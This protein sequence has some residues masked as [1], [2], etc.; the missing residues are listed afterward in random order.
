MRSSDMA[1]I[2]LKQ[3]DYQID[4]KKILDSIDLAVE[5]NDYLTI[6]G[7][8][9]SGKSTVL[10][11]MA[12]MATATAGNL[13]YNQT[14]IAELNPV[15]Y[16]R[17]VSYC[18]Q[19]PALFGETVA[20]N[21][22]FPA[23]VRGVEFDQTRAVDLLTKV[24]LPA[25]MMDEKIIDIS[26]GERQRIGLLRHLMYVPKVLLLDE[27]TTGLDAENKAIVWNLIQ[28]VHNEDQV[29]IISVTH[30]QQEIDSAKKMIQIIE[31]R[32]GKWI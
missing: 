13:Y 30:D 24:Q 5:P 9:G 21:L 28:A 3:V 32:I 23:E 11:L 12:Q 26:G 1:I 16:R 4:D 10:L 29:T 8:S 22:K 27:I 15:E 19:R 31:G 17:E 6:T 25:S 2:E 20:D 7:P 14:D 18:V